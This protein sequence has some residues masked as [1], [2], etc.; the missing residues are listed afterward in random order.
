MNL[1]W[2]AA[3]LSLLLTNPHVI[4]GQIAGGRLAACFRWQ[5]PDG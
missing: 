4:H 5:V 1:P 2:H 3:T